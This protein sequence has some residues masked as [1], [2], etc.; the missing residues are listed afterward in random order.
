M[1][2]RRR[3]TPWRDEQPSPACI[4]M[5]GYRHRSRRANATCPRSKFNNDSSSGS[6]GTFYRSHVGITD[7]RHPVGNHRRPGPL[8][9][10][11]QTRQRQSNCIFGSCVFVVSQIHRC[12][13]SVM[14]YTRALRLVTDQEQD[15][16]RS[17]TLFCRRRQSCFVC[18]FFRRQLG[19]ALIHRGHR[20]LDCLTCFWKERERERE[21]EREK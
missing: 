12:S 1:A 20:L 3:T 14:S 10:S 9:V 15:L 4:S 21:R 18:S 19:R 17:L 2:L 11:T 6:S 8:H 13:L 5:S 16:C 7:E